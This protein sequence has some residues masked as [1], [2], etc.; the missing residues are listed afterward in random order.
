[1]MSNQI[2]GEQLKLEAIERVEGNA[3]TDWT[4]A[5][6]RIVTRLANSR[7]EFT[8]DAVWHFLELADTAT[9]EPRAMGAIMR[10]CG[11]LGLIHA[12]GR[13]VMST[14]PE[15]HRRPIRVW[16]SKVWTGKVVNNAEEKYKP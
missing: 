9:H 5:A 3:N 12:T 7:F 4:R 16:R 8:T 10:K 6:L 2:L 15:C 14:R 1:M 13:T 11:A